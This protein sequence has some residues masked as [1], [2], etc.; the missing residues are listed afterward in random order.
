MVCAISLIGATP[1]LFV[2][3]LV[4]Q[5]KVIYVTWAT[6]FLTIFFACLNWTPVSAMLLVSGWVGFI[7]TNIKITL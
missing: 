4:V 3:L 2:S 6:V 1:M 7:F 5:Y